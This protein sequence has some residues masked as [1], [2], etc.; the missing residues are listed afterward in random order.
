MA[1]SNL[2]YPYDD[3]EMIYN[4][5]EHRYVLTS[6]GVTSKLGVVLQ[7]VLQRTPTDNNPSAAP[8]RFLDFV[9]RHFYGY[10][11]RNIPTA[12]RNVIEWVLAKCPD[13]RSLIKQAMFNEVE[14]VLSEG[15]FWNK[16]GVNVLKGSVMDLSTLRDTRVVSYDTE[17]L[18]YSPIP[19]FPYP[20]LYR[21]VIPTPFGVQWRADY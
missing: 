13:M 7:N 21:G 11:Y 16:S 2:T 20:L 18:L 9:S 5:A 15:A 12:N 3:P 8:E 10:I 6:D 1:N 14:Y 19:S 4:R 17:N